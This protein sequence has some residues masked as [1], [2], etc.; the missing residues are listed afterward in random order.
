VDLLEDSRAMRNEPVVAGGAKFRRSQ[1]HQFISNPHLSTFRQLSPKA[2]AF[3]AVQQASGTSATYR[4]L[5]NAGLPGM[6]H[7]A[8][9]KAQNGR[10]RVTIR[11]DR[12]TPLLDVRFSTLD[13]PNPPTMV[14]GIKARPQSEWDAHLFQPQ[15]SFHQSSKSVFRDSADSIPSF[16]GPFELVTAPRRMLSQRSA[17]A[18]I[19]QAASPAT[20]GESSYPDSTSTVE[21][22]DTGRVLS[23][24]SIPDSLQAVRDL[25]GQFPGPPMALKD[26]HTFIEPSVWEEVPIEAPVP[27]VFGSP[28]EL[29][30]KEQPPRMISGDSA[31]SSIFSSPDLFSDNGNTRSSRQPTLYTVAGTSLQS[32]PRYSEKPLD[33][34]ND[35]DEE[36]AHSPSRPVMASKN[37]FGAT[38]PMFR[39]VNGLQDP[40]KGTAD[41][42]AT[43][44][45]TEKSRISRL[46]NLPSSR[47]ES[48]RKIDEMIAG[49]AEWIGS[50]S[51]ASRRLPQAETPSELLLQQSHESDNMNID[52]LAI[53]WLKSP[54]MEEEG[55]RGL[56]KAVSKRDIPFYR[57][58][59]VG[60]TLTPLPIHNRGS[61]HLK[62]II[63]PPLG[64]SMPEVVDE[65][66]YGSLES[67]A[68]GGG[69][70]RDSEVLGMRA[71]EGP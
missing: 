49:T 63:I 65:Y 29:L 64:E 31:S 34:F 21:P 50:R 6:A 48:L 46:Q 51:R 32:A 10:Q 1:I 61:M 19:Y 3:H 67:T 13:I 20:S 47:Q 59:S 12:G 69:I 14:E 15:P 33:P 8:N 58:E 22:Q 26:Q 11:Y 28:S 38:V 40:E 4:T 71:N 2:T 55:D 24:K 52:N 62:P 44:L 37:T 27:Q 39:Q 70:L 56:V 36:D 17:R 43:T 5:T 66:G 16:C 18:Q 35:D 57:V 45:D 9:V 25:A 60:K 30:F 42:P 7:F 68:T 54:H 53:S 41:I 23:M